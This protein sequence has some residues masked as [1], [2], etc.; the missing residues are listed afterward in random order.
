[1]SGQVRIT[2]LHAW[3][4]LIVAAPGWIASSDPHTRHTAHLWGGREFKRLVLA[5]G[6]REVERGKLTGYP[7][8]PWPMR[9]S[10]YEI[11]G[12]AMARLDQGVVGL[13]SRIRG[14]A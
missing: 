9:T 4:A 11:D 6:G 8:G 2:P 10:V 14:R 1:M 3:P 5:L 13:A 12:A 7:R